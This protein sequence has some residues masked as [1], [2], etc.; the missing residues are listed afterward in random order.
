MP[1]WPSIMQSDPQSHRTGFAAEWHEVT[2][3]YP[4]ATRQVVGPVSIAV[5]PGERVLLLGP[6]GS[7]KSTL[8]LTLTG[9]VSNSI[10]ATVSGDIC[11]FGVNVGTRQ[12]W[13]WAAQ[14]AQYFQDADQTLCGMRVEDEIAFALENRALPPK[15]IA[16]RVM[17]AMQR[18]GVPESW[19]KRPT[20]TLS[21]GERQLV[22]L[23]A[24]L[25]QNAPLFVADEPTAHLAPQAADRLHALLTEHDPHRSVLIVDHRL[26]G[27]IQHIDRMVVLGRDGTILAEGHPRTIFRDERD[28]LASEGIWCPVATM[29]DAQLEH[30]G[31]APPAAPLSVEEALSHVDPALSSREDV[32]RAIPAVK[33]FV[34]EY[35]VRS[36]PTALGAPVL[37]ELVKADCAPFLGPTILRN[38]D[39]AIHQGEILGIFGANGAG[40]S[41]LGLCLSGLLPLKAGSRT[42]APGGY[43]FQRPENQFTVGTV[44][45]EILDALPEQVAARDKAEHVA[46][47]LATWGL[48]GLENRHPFELSQGQKRRLALATLTVSDRWP[49]LV[50]DEPTAGLD[51]LGVSTLMREMQALQGRGHAIAV[52]TH[53]MDLALRLCPR[54]I[55]VGEGGILADGPTQ[56]LM[57]DTALL[58]RA[59]LAEP[60]CAIALQWL[61]RVASC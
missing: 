39:L 35:A 61:H 15:H 10:P 56:E 8:L 49:V 34:A 25:V 23:A 4:F 27:L 28:L 30:A 6:S 44:R 59:G 36:A 41:T 50:L 46:S 29:L 5:R 12:P 16:D 42:G 2:V 57:S 33:A 7:G 45:D 18:V 32:D 24:T 22:A 17:E 14:V 19:R 58:R 20:S 3:Q 13:A 11:L 51:A 52:I 21:G 37:A 54:S 60:S 48:S 47:A 53:D 40:K 43:A 1:V 55:V 26:E 31:I 38:I 9:L